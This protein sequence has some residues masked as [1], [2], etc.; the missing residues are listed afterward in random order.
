[1]EFTRI[2]AFFKLPFLQI[3]LWIVSLS[4]LG[5]TIYRGWFMR[6]NMSKQEVIVQ[7]GGVNVGQQNVE[8]KKKLEPFFE[9]YVQVD[10]KGE[11]VGG[12]KGGIRF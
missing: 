6:T 2:K 9:P 10:T 8:P 7:A 4:F 11:F 3:I 1:M 5:I 12:I